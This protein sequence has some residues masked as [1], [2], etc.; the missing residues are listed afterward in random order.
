MARCWGLTDPC[1]DPLAT[2]GEASG[3]DF[4]EGIGL[5]LSDRPQQAGIYGKVTY[6]GNPAPNVEL[7]LQR[8]RP[9]T[10]GETTLLTVT[11]DA[12]GEYAFRNVP[13]LPSGNRYYVR[14]SNP[15]DNLFV[16]SWFAPDIPLYAAGQSI[17]GGDFDIQDVVLK[18]PPAGAKRSLPAVFTWQK[19]VPPTDTFVWRLRT[20]DFGTQ[21]LSDDLGLVDSYTLGELYTGVN[22]NTSY[23]WLMHVYSGADSFGISYYMRKVSFS[24]A[25]ATPTPTTSPTSTTVPTVGPTATVMPTVP[26]PPKLYV[27]HTVR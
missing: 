13:N 10:A 4:S 24:A 18:S 26:P 3:A 15:N 8:Y 23:W 25:T 1:P 7:T 21:W 9:G 12:N 6:K 14:Y 19:R 20:E 2:A 22:F 11:T 16:G 17:A 27:P 5:P